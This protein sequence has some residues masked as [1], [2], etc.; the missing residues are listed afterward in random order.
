MELKISKLIESGKNKTVTTFYNP[1]ELFI[2]VIGDEGKRYTIVI[3]RDNEKSIVIRGTGKDCAL[4]I[5][6]IA[7]N[8]IKIF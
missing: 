1:E 6:P 4:N 7:S 2:E 8:S 3:E 5:K